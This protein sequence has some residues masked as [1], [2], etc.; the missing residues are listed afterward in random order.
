MSVEHMETP[1][2]QPQ[3][4][5]QGFQSRFEVRPYTPEEAKLVHDELEVPNWPDWLQASTDTLAARART[6]PP[7]Q[8]AL[9]DG[10]KMVAAINLQRFNYSGKPEDLLTWDE[11]CGNPPTFEEKYDPNGNAV[12]MMSINVHKDYQGQGLSKEIIEAVRAMTKREGITHVLGSF[13]PS[14][15]DE[16]LLQNPHMNERDYIAAK[17]EHDQLPVDGWLRIL[18]R[19]GMRPLRVDDAAMVVE[20]PMDEFTKYKQTYN[21]EK[22]RQVGNQKHMWRCGETGVW[23]VNHDTATYIES[24]VWGIL[25]SNPAA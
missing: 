14:Q 9:W 6:F 7:G 25:E 15:M 23:Y 8:I 1:P 2:S 19:N 17:R 13:R 3:V 18:T 4:P 16:F 12:G 22:W 10:Q 21:P 24:N 11:L 5:E 20:V